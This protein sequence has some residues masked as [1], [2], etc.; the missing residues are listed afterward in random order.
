M[1]QI[2]WIAGPPILLA[3]AIITWY[4]AL[5][6]ADCYRSPDPVS[7]RRNY[8]YMDAVRANLG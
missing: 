2:G 8:T 5:L 4:M 1:A 6:L 7:G 3:F